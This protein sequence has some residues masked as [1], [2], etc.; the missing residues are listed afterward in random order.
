[1][2][3]STHSRLG[4]QVV[5]SKLFF[6]LISDENCSNYSLCMNIN[7]S[8]IVSSRNYSALLSQTDPQERL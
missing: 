6:A 3:N 2:V 5:E 1:M 8:M 7:I 4:Y